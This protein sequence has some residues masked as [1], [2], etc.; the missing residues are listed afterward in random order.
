VYKTHK[1]ARGVVD[2]YSAGVHLGIQKESNRPIISNPT[3][4]SSS[5]DESFDGF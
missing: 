2:F 4:S 1:T 5:V 3:F